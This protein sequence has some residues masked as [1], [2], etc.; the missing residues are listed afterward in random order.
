MLVH[1]YLCG[2]QYT[3]TI[4]SIRWQRNG[5]GGFGRW[6][7]CWDRCSSGTLPTTLPT[8]TATTAGGKGRRRQQRRNATE[9]DGGPRARTRILGFWVAIYGVPILM[10]PH[11][12]NGGGACARVGN[13]YGCWFE[14]AFALITVAEECYTIYMCTYVYLYN[15][16]TLATVRPKR[17]RCQR[18]RRYH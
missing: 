10:S 5:G 7:V 8:T 2:L 9:W 13:V 1:I 4:A 16:H 11:F 12:D 14:C 3:Y 15:V 18:A 6:H 17:Y